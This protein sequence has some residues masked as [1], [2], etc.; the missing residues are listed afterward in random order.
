[1][2]GVQR[3]LKHFLLKDCKLKDP[4]NLSTFGDGNFEF[5]LESLKGEE[6]CKF[7]ASSQSEKETWIREIGY[8][9]NRYRSKTNSF[10]H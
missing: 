1:M 7:I 9:L 4:G 3:Y 2:F 8:V 6:L 10:R 5:S